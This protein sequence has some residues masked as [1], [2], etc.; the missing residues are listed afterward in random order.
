MSTSTHAA[1]VEAQDAVVLYGGA[2]LLRFD[3]VRHHYFVTEN[4]STRR[5]PSV[6]QIISVLEKPGLLQWGANCGAEL[7][8][9]RLRPGQALDEVEIAELCD[10]IRFAHRRISGRAKGV[11]ALA[12]DWIARYL[13]SLVR[14]LPRMETPPLPVN[15]QARRACLA[16]RDWLDSNHFE[17]LAVEQMVYSR[18]HGYAGTVDFPSRIDGRISLTDWKTSAAIY[19]EYHL[20]LAAYAEA[21]WE[22]TPDSMP[23]RW[24]VRLS[25]AD[26]VFETVL[27][28]REQQDADLRAFVAAKTLFERLAQLR[29]DGRR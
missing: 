2:V 3:R 20:Q 4:G 25:K 8:A 26:G 21:W 27:L 24:L 17:P 28:P 16:A 15:E 18:R 1:P 13:A 22:M 23:D 14:T 29:K 5:V 7:L 9:K 10:A 6:T 19:P 12:H 11:G